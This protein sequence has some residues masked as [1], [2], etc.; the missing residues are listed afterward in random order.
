[1]SIEYPKTGLSLHEGDIHAPVC[2]FFIHRCYLCSIP[3]AAIL[4]K[5]SPIHLTRS[6]RRMPMRLAN[7]LKIRLARC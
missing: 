2:G 7:Q 4:P 1:M 3:P 5:S 6:G